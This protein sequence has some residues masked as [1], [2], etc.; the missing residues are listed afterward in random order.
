M[1][2]NGA[3]AAIRIPNILV[4]FVGTIVGGRG[5]TCPENSTSGRG[6]RALGVGMRSECYLSI[7][8][9]LGMQGGQKNVMV[10]SPAEE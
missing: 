3:V 6:D 7:S 10:L 1:I 5:K 8:V 9:C 4:L 2:G